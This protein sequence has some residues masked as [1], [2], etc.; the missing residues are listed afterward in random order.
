MV[1][2][3]I[4]AA[5]ESTRTHP[6]T[7]TKHKGLLKVGNRFILEHLLEALF[8]CGV[9]ETILVVGYKK[10]LITAKFGNEFKGMKIT[11]VVQDEAKGTMHALSL[12]KGLLKDRFIVHYGD[13]IIT[14]TDLK[15]VLEH[16]YAMLLMETDAPERFGIATLDE[17]GYLTDIVEKPKEHI[18]NLASIGG[19]MFDKRIFD[20]PM[21]KAEGQK[22]YYIPDVLR[23]LCKD[24]KVKG[25]IME[26]Y[27]LPTGYPWDLLNANEVVTDELSY[28]KIEGE[29]EEGAT[30]KGN[31]H[32]GAGTIVKAGTYIEGNCIIGR[33]CTIGP[34]AYIR[35][36][37]SIGDNCTVGNFVTVKNSI[38]MDNTKV[39]HLS[40][41]ADSILGEGVNIGAG[42]ITANLKHDNSHVKAM[43]KDGIKSTGRRKFGAVI[44][45]NAKTGIKTAFYPGRMIWPGKSTLPMTV[46]REDVKG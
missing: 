36:G 29:V 14:A 5:G 37:S 8:E 40:Y 35:P 15:K 1:Q 24:I 22:E 38:L 3:V 16:D 11:Y 19:F 13:D 21:T 43:S 10:E 6:L 27:W 33:N 32:I 31:V 9:E 18:G 39:G 42:T 28:S 44:A 7:L 30:I 20:Y 25:I 34:S 12:A 23:M 41:I 45:D 2:A 4:L 26:S 46:V 17:E